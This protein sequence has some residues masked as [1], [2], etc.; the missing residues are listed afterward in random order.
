MAET[1]ADARDVM[2]E[3][4]SG[5]LACS[6]PD[7][8]PHY[9]P[10]K[11]RLTWKNGSKATTYSAETPGQLRGPQHHWAWADELAKWRYMD[12]WDQLMFGL[13]LG[14]D[15]RAVVTTT[16]RPIPIIKELRKDPNCVVTTGSTYENIGNLAEV[17]TQKIVQRYEGTRLGRQ[18]LYA[19]VLDDAPGALWKRGEL[20]ALRVSE[21][22]R[23]RRIIVAVDPAVS[24]NTNSNETG[25]IVVGLGLDGHGYVLADE[26]L[27]QA[28][29]DKWA[30]QV[31]AAYWRHQA[32]RVIAEVN[33]GGDLVEANVR[34]V[35]QN[36]PFT[37]V[38][39][40]RGKAI[41]AE[42]VQ[43]LYEQF[44]VHHVGYFAL[45]EDQM[46]GWEP[47]V[48]PKSPDRVDALVWGLT[49]LMVEDPFLPIAP[50][51]SGGESLTR[52]SGMGGRGF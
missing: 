33:N 49:H 3:G 45:L 17:F 5:I 9:E 22:P 12:T 44:K 13:R 35:S 31:V 41:R 10:S 14:K 25:I 4:E 48:S 36:I 15:P 11:R 20:D 2:V 51:P 29:P 38:R 19:E 52:W 43:A 40:T 50:P 27:E 23:L 6:P 37:Q 47:G 18:E 32:D 42:P 16:P 24:E 46:C 1:A 7:F 8:V 21:T 26:S 34:T 28:T 30:T 39:A